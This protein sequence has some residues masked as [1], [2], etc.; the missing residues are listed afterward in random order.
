MRLSVGSSF[1]HSPHSFLFLSGPSSLRSF[2]TS[3]VNDEKRSEQ[4]ERHERT[5]DK[6]RRTGSN[7][8]QNSPL[9]L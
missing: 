3:G 6:E 7:G 8:K 1:I 5:E 9:V 2:V 4:N